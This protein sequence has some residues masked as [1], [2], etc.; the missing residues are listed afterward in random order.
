VPVEEL[1]EQ[2]GANRTFLGRSAHSALAWLGGLH[3]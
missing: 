2:L 3:R 1:A